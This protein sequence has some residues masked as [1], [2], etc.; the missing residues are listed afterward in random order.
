MKKVL[1]AASLLVCSNA[2]FA[3]VN[4]GQWLVGGSVGFDHSSQGDNKQTD[5]TIAPDAGY[6]FINQLAAGLR[7]EFGY[8][9]TKTKSG[10]STNTGSSTSFGL[11][12]FV[13]YYFMPSGQMLNIFADASY[14]F[15]SS[16]EKGGES[17]SGN[18]YQIKAGPAVFLTPNTAL[19]FALYY[20]SYGGDAFEV[21]DDRQNHFGL[22]VGF[23]IHLGGGAA[24]K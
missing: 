17:V 14:G 15:G 1:I 13:R 2:I 11:A 16:K 5:I 9:K 12:P 21:A 22:N 6:F 19:E 24:K 4:K 8:T 10:T 7:P 20:K 18:Y 3:Q 23:Q